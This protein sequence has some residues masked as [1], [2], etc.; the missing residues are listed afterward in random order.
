APIEEKLASPSL[1]ALDRRS[2]Q[3]VRRSAN[4]LLTLINQL[5]DLSKLEAK[6]MNLVVQ[7]GNMNELL[8]VVAASFDSFAETR[9][10]QFQKDIQFD[11]PETWF[12]SDKLEKILC[13]ILIN[14]FKFTQAEG[15][16]TLVAETAPHTYDLRIRITD[17]GK[18][19]PEHELPYV[20]Y[21]FY[22]TRY[23]EDDS[24][25]GTGLGLSLVKELVN[26]HHGTIDLTSTVNVGTTITITIPVTLNR[27]PNAT[28]K[29]SVQGS[30]RYLLN[31]MDEKIYQLNDQRGVDQRATQNE[32]EADGQS[33]LETVLI[34]E[35]NHDLRNFI[36]NSLRDQF[37]TLTAVNGEEGYNLA[38]E[39]I[40]DLIISDVMMPIL[41]GIELS[42]KLKNDERTSHIPIVLL[43]AKADKDSRI[44]GLQ[45]GADDYLAKPFSM[46][47]LRVRV[48][49]LIEQ[50]KKLAA[51]YRAAIPSIP[52]EPVLHREL[53]LDEKFLLRASKLVEDNISDSLFG[54]EQ[55]AKEIGLS[56]AQLFRKL[57]AIAGISPNEF[58]NEIRLQ[59]AAKLILSK[60]DTLAQI[61]YS[62][63]FNEQSYFAKCFRKKFGV[64]P[65]EYAN[66]EVGQEA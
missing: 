56:R 33:K 48:T 39:S 32:D 3:L 26:L 29:P 20:F 53:T 40:P 9:K 62:V 63:G 2:F 28:I 5:L 6:K 59:K 65:S 31:G 58:I 22:Q 52:I 37:I 13:N 43:T 38:M 42:A 12:D 54:V 8:R 16:V 57:K 34:I 4:R 41:N 18:G 11:L 44:E 19:I 1:N 60:T 21:P 36:S 46:D 23:N 10:I 45:K 15:A 14:A 66:K 35:D 7:Q 49:N 30:L 50:R 51:K 25:M 17:T 64:S 61:G 27:L 24:S 47:E 55:M